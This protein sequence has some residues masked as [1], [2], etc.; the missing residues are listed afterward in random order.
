LAVRRSVGP[1]MDID[2]ARMCSVKLQTQI[3]ILLMVK[4]ILRGETDKDAP[5]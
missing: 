5:F 1:Q 2:S 4:E 3:E